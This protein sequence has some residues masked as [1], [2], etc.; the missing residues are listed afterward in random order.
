MKEKAKTIFKVARF[1]VLK[2]VGG[3]NWD[4]L[5]EMLREARYRVF[6]LANLA[7]SEAYLNFHL[8]RTGKSE[9]F[10]TRTMGELSRGLREMLREEG[11]DEER[12]N[13]FS[14]TGVLPDTVASALYQYKIRAITSL[15]KW[16][17]V[18]R[19]TVSL[20]TFRLDMAIPIRCDKPYQRRLERTE[21]GEV[22]VDLM[23]CR[24]PYPRVVLQTGDIG[25]G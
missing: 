20:P 22:E 9:E 21:S 17:Q 24:K 2:P 18:V 1:R 3:M 11:T 4:E 5:G 6:R 19:G 7:V 25:G 14:Q 10:K 8:F 15:S 13:R 12:L 23:I 16:R